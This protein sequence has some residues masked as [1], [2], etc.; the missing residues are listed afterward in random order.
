[1]LRIYRK[2]HDENEQSLMNP[3]VD[4]FL[5]FPRALRDKFLDHKMFLFA[6][7]GYSGV[8]LLLALHFGA[9]RENIL[10][11][12]LYTLGP[13]FSI[14]IAALVAHALISVYKTPLTVNILRYFET[15]SQNTERQYQS[16]FTPQSCALYVIVFYCMF[17][18][19]WAFLVQKSLIALIMPHYLDPALSN[20]DYILH[21]GY[22]PFELLPSLSTSFTG[23]LITEQAYFLWFIFI[24]AVNVYALLFDPDQKRRKLYLWSSFCIWLI[25]GCIGAILMS[26]VGPIFYGDFYPS[27]DNPYSQINAD[28]AQ[29]ESMGAML[30]PGAVSVLLDFHHNKDVID[31]NG[32][33]AM[34][35]M[36]VAASMLSFLYMRS[37]N[38]TLGILSGI[39]GLAILICSVILGFHYAIDGYFSILAVLLIWFFCKRV[40][41]YTEDIKYKN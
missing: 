17:L 39:Y 13:T 3:I 21:F 37:V 11:T 20:I 28:M 26:S 25:L 23:L 34:P 22:Y 38:R 33:T 41:G 10:D 24:L 16:A 2:N 40:L 12:M 31:L 1:M 5:V 7:T 14:F 29:A 30:W 36:H 18:F 9:T 27:L 8:V 4:Q 15:L 19:F 35:S 32:I 6:C